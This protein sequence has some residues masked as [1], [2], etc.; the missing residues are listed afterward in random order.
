MKKIGITGGIAS[1]KST[2]SQYLME[3]GFHVID[4]DQISR[5]LMEPGQVGYEKVTDVFGQDFV[6]VS[7]EID[8]VKLAKRIFS[9]LN[10][11]DQLNSILHPL[12]FQEIEKEIE[13]NQKLEVIFI[14]M[15]L[16]FETGY[17]QKLDQV[18]LVHVPLELQ[19]KRLKLRNHLSDQEALC[20]IES[21]MSE[22]D[23]M[24]KAQV[25]I[26][27][28]GSQEALFE[29]VENLLTHLKRGDE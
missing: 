17:D 13:S 29:Q 27:N 26:N 22:L 12:I 11:R 14:D 5:R 25:I 9:D 6:L 21:Q 19:I 23:R 1:G 2:L 4:A 28:N 20:R 24:K 7:G 8:R 15:P 16:L 18:W 3:K 10:L